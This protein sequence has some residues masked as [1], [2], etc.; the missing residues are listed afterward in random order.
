MS[1]STAASNH[2]APRRREPPAAVF[3]AVNPIMK[4]L[5]RSPLHGLVSKRMM[6]LEVTGRKSG[7]RYLIPI[8]YTRAGDTLYAGTKG[9]WYKNLVGGAPLR[10]R[11]G[12][13]W[14]AAR[15]DVIADVEGMRAAYRQ[16]LPL[17]P[18]YVRILGVR[19]DAH[20]EPDREDVE[21]A[22]RDGHVVVRV[23]PE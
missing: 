8:G 5:L 4:A 1:S 9:R 23:R 19:L 2:A 18:H 10:V 6:L 3:R 21:A 11:L 7:A 16:F 13:R 17:A 12:G 22:Q 20:G 15:G 14:L